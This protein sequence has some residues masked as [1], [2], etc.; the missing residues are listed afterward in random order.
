MI[1]MQHHVKQD[2]ESFIRKREKA[3]A[4]TK[5]GEVLLEGPG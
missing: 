3:K 4:R 2:N 5:H 1:G